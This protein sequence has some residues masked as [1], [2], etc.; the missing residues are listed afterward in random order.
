MISA[1]DHE[2]LQVK[3]EEYQKIRSKLQFFVAEESETMP[4][5]TLTVAFLAVNLA[6]LLPPVTTAQRAAPTK[7]Q[8]PSVPVPAYQRFLSPASPLEVVAARTVDRL[9]WTS[10]HEGLRNAYTAAAP[11][12][13]PVRL[14]HFMTD[15]GT[16]LSGI[17]ISDDGS[18]VIFVRGTTPNRDGWVANPTADPN[19]PERAVWAV[20][21]AG[22]AAWRVVRDAINPELAPD[23]SA[24]L[25]VKDGQVYRA[26]VTPTRPMSEMDRGEKP[27]ITQ[28]GVQSGPKWSPDGRKIAFVSTPDRPQLHHGVRRCD[29]KREV[30]VAERRLRHEPALD[31]GQPEHRLRA[32]AGLPFGQ[33]AQQG[34]G[35]VG[36]PNGPA[37]QPN[38]ESGRGGRGR[39]NA[40]PQQENLGG[41][42][43]G[44]QPTGPI[45][46]I[47]GLMQAT[48]KGGYNLSIW[49]GDVATGAAVEVWH[50]QPNDRMFTN[51]ANLRLAGDYLIVPFNVGGGGRG[52]RG[53]QN[54]PPQQGPIDEWERYYSINLA[55]PNAQPVLLTT[56]DGLIEDQT[57]V[58]L[59]ADR[60]TLYYCTNAKDTERRHI[61]AVPV[62]GGSP[63]QVTTGEGIET[64]P[65]PLASG[66]ALATLSADWRTPQSLGIWPLGP[67][68]ASTQKIVF[69]ASLENFPRDAH[70]KPELVLTKA[71]DG[72]EIRTS[73]S[74]QE[75]QARRASSGDR[76][77]AWRPGAPDAAR[78][79]LPAVL[80]WAY[81]VNQ[82][83][84]NQGYI[85]LSVNYRSGVGYGRRSARRRTPAAAETPNI[86]TC[87]RQG[88]TS[89]RGRTWT[90][91]VSASGDSR[92]AAC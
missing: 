57:S 47:P 56:T 51:F 48:F 39:G 21:T 30:H 58:A 6:L 40:G 9:A 23:G 12:F 77:R 90:R 34:S 86:T 49:K 5:R 82:W 66:K 4:V 19:G 42:G 18:T 70:V 87:S 63:T 54:P 33:Q 43:G 85:V 25:F 13:I 36:L 24:I 2:N 60:R 61:W 71:P 22:G 89:R 81:G 11:S 20:R 28:W 50:N 92:T 10:F 91:R 59:S 31:R 79:S 67:S 3:P 80:P 76:L 14:T 46:N 78:L 16:D 37:F 35:G 75:H 32:P 52:G 44:D 69:P 83:L 74:F 38:A 55:T 62:S 27:F 88:S 41:R 7:Q 65:A 68:P 8:R 15:N 64:Y 17:R 26:R 84:A 72:L 29:A 73:S 53:A 45:A 1:A